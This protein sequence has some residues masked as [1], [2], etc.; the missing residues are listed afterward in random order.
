MDVLEKREA[1]ADAKDSKDLA[2]VARLRVEAEAEERRAVAALASAFHEPE[3]V[4]TKLHLLG[5]LRFFR[6]FLD[7]V[8]AVEESLDAS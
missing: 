6:R 8:A 2:A 7:E 1:L 4:A 5:E 3:T